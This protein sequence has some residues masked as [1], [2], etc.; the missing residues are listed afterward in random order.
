MF[1]RVVE[2]ICK[3]GQW[4]DRSFAILAGAFNGLPPR[5]N[6]E[7]AVWRGSSFAEHIGSVD[8]ESGEDVV[9]HM[10]LGA[11]FGVYLGGRKITKGIGCLTDKVCSCFSSDRCDTAEPPLD[12]CVIFGR[13]IRHQDQVGMRIKHLRRWVIRRYGQILKMRDATSPA[14]VGQGLNASFCQV[15]REFIRNIEIQR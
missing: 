2:Q 5:R 6:L 4:T 9:Q 3:I 1:E 7:P 11:G 8:P 10:R 14:D 13:V 12:Q 15:R